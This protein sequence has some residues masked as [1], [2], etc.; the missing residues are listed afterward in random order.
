VS[1]LWRELPQ[2]GRPPLAYALDLG[3]TSLDQPPVTDTV[4]DVGR[5]AHLWPKVESALSDFVTQTAAE[6]ALFWP[7]E[8]RRSS[9]RL[10]SEP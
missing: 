1:A 7:R 6:H 2:D 3:P 10:L 4:E 5:R 9:F 8:L